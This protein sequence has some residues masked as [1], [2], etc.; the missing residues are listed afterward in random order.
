MFILCIDDET[1][2]ICNRLNLEKAVII[3]LEEI[4][5][6]KL[7]A[8]K[9]SRRLNEYC[10]TLKPFF[11]KYV[12]TNY[13]EVEYA[14]YMDA[15]ICFFNDPSII[16]TQH[17]DCSVLLSEHDFIEENSDVE[18]ICGKY[19]SGFIIFKRCKTSLNVLKWWRDKCLD[20]CF[21]SVSEGRFGDQK[22]VE[23]FDSLFEGVKTIKT[24]GVNIAPWN[25]DRY[26]FSLKDDKVYVNENKLI[27]YHFCGLRI[28]NKDEFALLIGSQLINNLI[29]D[30][31]TFVIKEVMKEIDEVYPNFEGY[32]LEEHFIDRAK[33]FKFEE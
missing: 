1:Y 26:K 28:I 7:L 18:K 29:H 4:E 13:N 16:F 32:S 2:D 21:D 11:L 12:L 25:D 9:N 23:Q 5:N 22:Y 24:P 6:E 10:W 20:W 15:D 14:V 31:Y 8:V 19:N 17:S 30:P 3:K 33:I 27:C